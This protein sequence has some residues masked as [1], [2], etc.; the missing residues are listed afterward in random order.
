M[1]KIVFALPLSLA[2]A[3]CGS[4]D[5][6]PTDLEKAESV[7]AAAALA[8]NIEAGEF[9]DLELGAKIVGPQGEEVTSALSNAEGN[10][11]D[12]RSFV[13]CPADMTECDPATAPEGTIYTY[14]HVV[15]PG[16]DNEAGTGS[17]EGNDSSDVERATAFRMTR[18]ATGFTGAAGYSKDA[19][20]AAIGA[21][22]DV[23]ITCDDGALVWTVSAGDGGDQWEQ[24][25]PL[26]FWWQSTVA[27]AGPVAAYAIDANY[28]QATGSGPYPADA[29]TATN[30]CNAPAVSG[31]E[32]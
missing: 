17:G 12:L 22:A 11:A 31:A 10:F 15:Y 25:E 18:P 32:G 2:L 4:A 5:E 7:G 9:L 8:R 14:V 13:A 28:A 16:E 20:M 26:T 30:A 19:A 1:N 24:A 3:A 23:V 29:P 21:K 27:P 6:P